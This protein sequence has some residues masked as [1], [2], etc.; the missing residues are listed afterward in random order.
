MKKELL[1]LIA[2]DSKTQAI[3]LQNLLEENG[4]ATMIGENGRKALELAR[5]RK[6]SLVISDI[7][8]PELD[9]YGLCHEIKADANLRDV[10]VILVTSLA[11]SEDV[12]R[13]L[14]SGADN[15]IRKPYE[16]RYLLSRIEYL[17]MNME[18]RENQKMRMGVEIKLGGK[19][20]FIT[21]E[22]QQILDLLISIYD[23]AVSINGDL[24]ER[25]R[26]LAYS[27]RVMQ[28]LYRISEGLNQVY[29][30]KEVAEKSLERAMELPGIEAGWISLRQ[31]ESGFRT[32]AVRNLPPA[33]ELPGALE[34]SCICRRMLLSGELDSVTN[35]IAC[36]RLQKA[37]GEKRGLR[38][39][40]SV[41]LWLGEKTIGVMNLVAP[42][43][44]LF[45]E[46]AKKVLYGIGNQVAAALERAKLHENLEHL[47][48]ERT[49]A[50]K[51]S[52]ASLK[53]FRTLLDR[54]ND[55]IEVLDPEDFRFL[56][57][58]ETACNVLGYG[59]EELLSMSIWDI[60]A[61]LDPGSEKTAKIQA[62]MK[63]S[64]HAQFESLHR[65]KDGSVFPVE[66][67]ATLVELDRPYYLSIAR[68]ITQ[69]KANEARIM[70]LNRVYAVLSGINTTIVRVRSRKALFDEV[71]RIAVELGK[72]RMAWIGTLAREGGELEFVAKAGHDEGY[73]DVLC[74]S[75]RA[76]ADRALKENG[77]VVCNDIAAD[78]ALSEIRHEALQRGYRCLAVFP[79]HESGSVVG[80]FALYAGEANYFDSEEMRLLLEV[81]GDISFG[82]DHLA[83]EEQLN[84]LAYYDVLTG[85]PNRT[86]FFD[87]LNQLL[88]T[89]RQAAV[90][91]MDLDRF[92][93]I[94]ETLGRHA[95]DSLLRQLAERLSK[96]VMERNHLS[97]MNADSF[98]AIVHDFE[99]ESDIVHFLTA[100][101]N[102]LSSP[103][104]VEGRELRVAVRFGIAIF[105]AN[106]TNADDLFRNAEASLKK[107]KLSGDRYLFYTPEIN[108][109]VSEKL[110][111][112]NK[113]RR[114][115]EEQ[116]F[117][118]YYQPKVELR[119]GQISSI[120][121]LIRWKDPESGLVPPGDFIPLL[122]ETGM[123]LEV[124][125][126][127]L[128][129]AASDSLKWRQSG[130]RPLRVAVNVSS[131][132]LKQKNFVEMVE[133]AVDGGASGIDLEI[134]ES[135]IMQDIEENMKK[136]HRVREMG[137]QIAVDDFGTGY[138]SL[139]YIARLPVNSLKIDRS[140]IVN[141]NDNPDNLAIV[142]AIIS[143]AHSLDM[144][145]TAEGVEVMEQANLL[146]L[147]KC[148]EI[149]GFLFSP[150]VPFDDI[151]RFLAEGKMLNEAARGSAG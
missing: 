150:A 132:Q 30:V 139:S 90:L 37:K 27:N 47:V 131:F 122:E 141:M 40:A 13:G 115:V 16:S 77:V 87:R 81:A 55:A 4:Y 118:L 126:W 17:V 89:V 146:K 110:T 105:P 104:E 49:S 57:I 61:G 15:F 26:E 25:E 137:M 46:E 56:D 100:I 43:E 1:V 52:E 76:L 134:T 60:D 149:Q 59:R 78:P 64:A 19:T 111:L 24:K 138:S 45:D 28:G 73:L 70:R 124:G 119:S 83:K 151:S 121:A 58:N 18:L 143:L 148:D 98:G 34:G 31:G 68:D 80:I 54:S 69:R 14:E 7:V 21:A 99:T 142:S 92:R 32:I 11:D 108:A 74:K 6:P 97:R 39:H 116:Q 130:P 136:L 38:Y 82:L 41:P 79:L 9:G 107:A 12:I 93:I 109:R 20:H 144:K 133:K 101:Q 91:V 22:K 117:V 53:L 106:G 48:E 95:G 51:A 135:L 120:E 147:L 42:D 5:K 62:Q 129:K 84:Y 2:E 72:F 145:V 88:N 33:L 114:A 50:L 67:N 96:G 125:R 66:I 10:P 44:G 103:F 23:Q 123:I 75:P 8:M 140:F 65:R 128:E 85:L 94:N 112:E 71:C 3:Q 29:G 127:A 63:E 36:E 86:L 102:A 113:L 35:I